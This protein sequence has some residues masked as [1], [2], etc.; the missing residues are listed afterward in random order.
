VRRPGPAVWLGAALAF[1]A[2][3]FLGIACMG[4]LPELQFHSHDRVKLTLALLA[5]IGAAVLIA[6]FG[7]V[8]H[9]HPQGAKNDSHTAAGMFSPIVPPSGLEATGHKA[10]LAYPALLRQSFSWLWTC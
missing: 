7:H 2:G 6:R 10:C 4:L 1:C 8:S 5:G 3:T 9:E